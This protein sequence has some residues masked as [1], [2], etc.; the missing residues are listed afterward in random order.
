MEWIPFKHFCE[1]WQEEEALGYDQPSTLCGDDVFFNE[2][3]IVT[4]KGGKWRKVYAL[5]S[6]KQNINTTDEA[7]YNEDHLFG[8]FPILTAA[9]IP[10]VSLQLL[11]L[12]PL[13]ALY[14]IVVIWSHAWE[15]LQ[16]FHNTQCWHNCPTVKTLCSRLNECASIDFFQNVTLVGLLYFGF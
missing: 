3:L 2:S 10:A 12:F 6:E 4:S 5:A 8:N 16:R 1:N 7:D 15:C 13:R 11:N 14:R 9:R